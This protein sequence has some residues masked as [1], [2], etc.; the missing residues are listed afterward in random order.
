MARGITE[1]DVHTAADELVAAG[2]R[3]TVDRIRTHLGTGSPNTVTRWLETWWRGLATR[4]ETHSAKLALPDVPEVVRTA[5][6]HVWEVAL[7][8]GRGQAEAS[9]APE[10]Q[11][12]TEA[13]ATLASQLTAAGDQVRQANAA[14]QQATAT[15]QAAEAA[16]AIS[17]QRAGELATQVSH[18][19]RQCE[20]LNQRHGV[21]ETQL[22]AALT[23][24]DQERAAAAA[25]RE[26]QQTHLRQTEDRAYAEID[27]LRQELKVAKAQLST[28]AREHASA[29][30]AAEQAQRAAEKAQHLA[31]RE[32][33]AA[34]ARLQAIAPTP[35][36]KARTPR[37][38]AT[39]G[40]RRA[41]AS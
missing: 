18:L 41:V 20:D 35:L 30:R 5:M 17:T 3:P 33:A 11:Q 28:Q 39:T 34:N 40:Q 22:Q 10:R 13:R 23:R 8:A 9:L 15:A 29:L 16:L 31:E 37:K 25:E 27:R 21:Q 1:T 26:D 4:L 6:G 24:L 32:S 14:E 12:L 7:E 38:T 36:P 2:E 19:Q